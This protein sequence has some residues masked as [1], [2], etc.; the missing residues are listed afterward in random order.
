M[1]GSVSPGSDVSGARTDYSG[2]RKAAVRSPHSPEACRH[3]SPICSTI[4]SGM[5]SSG[6]GRLGLLEP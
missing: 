4:R 1:V 5:S 6:W 2:E 3:P